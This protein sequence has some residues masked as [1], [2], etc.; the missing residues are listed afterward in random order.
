[1]RVV[2][3]EDA[4]GVAQGGEVKEVKRGFARNYLIP[5]GLATPASSDTLQRVERLKRQAEGTR[6]KVLTDMKALGEELDGAEVKVEMR[7]GASGRLFGSVTNAVVASELSKI[8]DREI[9]RRTV[10]LA[11]S[12]RN[13]GQYEV[14]V[15]LHQEVDATVKLLVYP[16]GSDPEEFAASLEEA[17][18]AKDADE[19]DEADQAEPA[20]ATAALEA[21]E[22]EEV[23]QAEP[24]EAAAA[25]EADEADE[26]AMEE[27]VPAESD[28]PQAEPE[29]ED[30]RDEVAADGE[31]TESDPPQE[32][33]TAEVKEGE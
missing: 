28:S 3:L 2:F 1:M 22:A 11:D 30:S 15:R 8:T 26:A 7:A 16:M 14:R 33:G 13:T 21:E 20:E 27:D 18:A 31:D 19:A 12:I 9:D 23:T 24:A 5:K 25:L 29:D 4:A 6:L 32:K 17:A 10:D